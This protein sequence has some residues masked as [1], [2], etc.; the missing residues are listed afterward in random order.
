[1]LERLENPDRHAWR[2]FFRHETA[3]LVASLWIALD[4]RSALEISRKAAPS[5]VCVA[6]TS[7]ENLEF[8]EGEQVLSR[9]EFK[10]F[11]AQLMMQRSSG[12]K[13]L[14]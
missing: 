7:E 14:L 6:D 10:G 13:E 11:Y 8:I 4:G 9:A 2:P 5:F 3:S 12:E 1:M